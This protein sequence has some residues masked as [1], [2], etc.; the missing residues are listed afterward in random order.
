MK[1]MNEEF[2]AIGN[3]YN[4]DYVDHDARQQYDDHY[5]NR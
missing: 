4:Y 1:T 2:D 3:N 5:D